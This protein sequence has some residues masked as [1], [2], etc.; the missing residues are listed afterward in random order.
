MREEPP[1]PPP[2]TGRSSQGALV[3]NAAVKMVGGMFCRVF[4]ANGSFSSEGHEVVLTPLV[5]GWL[6][7]LFGRA[8]DCDR[9]VLGKFA[10]VI[11]QHSVQRS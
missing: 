4:K 5:S 1:P 8:S 6:R 9:S 11:I 2:L 7:R 3:K 10:D